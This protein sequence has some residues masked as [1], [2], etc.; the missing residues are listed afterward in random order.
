MNRNYDW[1]A[2]RYC[3]FK[4]FVH[5]VFVT[6]YRRGVFTEAMLIDM[7]KIFE[8][9]CQKLGGELLQLGGEDDHVHLMVSVPPTIAL[10]HF[11]GRLKGASSYEIRKKYGPIIRKKLWGKHLWSPSYCV[12]SC[13]G[14][15]LEVVRKYIARQRALIYVGDIAQSNQGKRHTGKK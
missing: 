3:V 12:V 13:G 6:K 14:T 9:S 15:T 4:N 5:L 1:R 10:C 2:S 8:K 11:V 7:Q